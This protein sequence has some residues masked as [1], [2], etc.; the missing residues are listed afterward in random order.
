MSNDAKNSVRSVETTFEVLRALMNLWSCECRSK[1][2]R[3]RLYSDQYPI[4]IAAITL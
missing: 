4:E 3:D 1:R 2:S